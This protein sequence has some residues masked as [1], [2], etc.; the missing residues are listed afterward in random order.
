MVAR[1]KTAGSTPNGFISARHFSQ[2][3]FWP[4]GFE[5]TFAFP[6]AMTATPVF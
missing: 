1:S 4:A 5:G 6:D 2:M 3:R